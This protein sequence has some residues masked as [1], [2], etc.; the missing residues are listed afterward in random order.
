MAKLSLRYN[1]LS[2]QM[3]YWETKKGVEFLKHVGVKKGDSV[4][5]FGCRVGHYSI[6]AAKTVG[7][8][9]FVY[10]IDTQSNDLAELEQKKNIQK[11]TNIRIIK[12]FG[13]L[14]LSLEDK[15]IDVFLL[16]DVLH[17]FKETYRKKLYRQ[18]FRV[19]KQNGL[20]SV[21][22]KHSL[23]DNPIMEFKNMSLEKIMQEIENSNF[24]F[25]EKHCGTIS[26]DDNL[27]QGCVFNFQKKYDNKIL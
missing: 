16:Y 21:Y 2:P 12:T 10:A 5:D 27:N 4:L 20:L 22:P 14:S 9:G 6:P 7:S 19:L 23:E 26:H 18:A 1:K 17:Y 11:L 8:K 15:S 13:Q 25:V 24:I 3:L